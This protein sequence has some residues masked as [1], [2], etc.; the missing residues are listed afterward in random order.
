[1]A[2]YSVATV[3]LLLFSAAFIFLQHEKFG[4]TPNSALVSDYSKLPNY[5]NGAFQNQS[6]TPNFSGDDNVVTIFW[7]F[8]FNKNVNAEPHSTIPTKKVDI[9]SIPLSENVVIWFGHS[10]YYLQIDGKRFLIDPVFSGAASP[11]SFTTK[12][13]VGTDVYATEDFSAIDYLLITH[14]HWDHLDYET[15]VKLRPKVK[16]V[17]TGLGVAL[18]LKQWGFAEESIIEKN[19][20]EKAELSD[21]FSI[22]LQPTRHFSGRLFKK[23][24]SLW[25][26]FVLKTP[27]KKL[28][29][30]GDSGYDKHFKE[31]G[32][33]YGPFDVAFLECGQYNKNWK[34]IH[35]APEEVAQAAIDLK[36]RVL[37]PVHWAKF[38]LSLHSWK[39]PIERLTSA[40][41]QKNVQLLTPMIGEKVLLNEPYTSTQWWEQ[42]Q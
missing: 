12:S 10:S 18:H 41:K 27:T 17:V 11:V 25:T 2:F 8:F 14:D 31:T 9:H 29:L 15:I 1:M 40:A 20:Y 19:W 6:H 38:S 22:T 42:V 24:A 16:N 34:Y 36:A 37:F 4:K 32:E 33:K 39:E 35:M 28:Y 5:Q 13:F 23:N 7:N 21:G 3:L 26:S 30:G